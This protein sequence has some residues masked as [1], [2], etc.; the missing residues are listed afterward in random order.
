[1]YSIL[2][3]ALEPTELQLVQ[4]SYDAYFADDR[5]LVT[6]IREADALN[7]MIVADSDDNNQEDYVDLE[8]DVANLS[9][10]VK[11]LITK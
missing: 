11:K 3:S 5:N 8:V 9:D 6:L 4:Q 2:S 10:G 1:M 7:G